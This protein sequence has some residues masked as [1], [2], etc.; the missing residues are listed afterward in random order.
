MI[1][2]DTNKQRK[3]EIHKDTDRPRNR[4]LSRS[5]EPVVQNSAP[6]ETV[7]PR[8]MSANV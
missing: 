2:K 8:Q 6:V 3:T 5:D 7:N 1:H 4:D